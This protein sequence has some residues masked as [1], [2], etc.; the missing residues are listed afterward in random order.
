MRKWQKQGFL[1]EKRLIIWYYSRNL[2]QQMP[3]IHELLSEA[4]TQKLTLIQG[5]LLEFAEFLDK[6]KGTSTLAQG[7][8]EGRNVKV[9]KYPTGYI[10]EI[11]G[12]QG[13]KMSFAFSKNDF[14]VYS[15]LNGN[16]QLIAA[17]PDNNN[18]KGLSPHPAVL[19]K[20]E[21]LTNMLDRRLQSLRQ[22]VPVMSN[23]AHQSAE[24]LLG[25]VLSLESSELSAEWK[26]NSVDDLE[27]RYF[28]PQSRGLPANLH[29]DSDDYPFLG[30]AKQEKTEQ[31]YFYKS[32]ISYGKYDFSNKDVGWKFHL[33]VLPEHAP[34]VSK[35]LKE[36]NFYHKYLFGGEPN[37][38]KIFTLYIGSKKLADQLA[39]ELNRDIGQYLAYPK[40][41]EEIEFSRGVVGRFCAIREKNYGKGYDKYVQYGTCGTSCLRTN[42]LR[43]NE[44]IC[45][46][47]PAL[48]KQGL[49][50]EEVKSKTLQEAISM[51]A[52]ATQHL[53]A[54]FGE[55]FSG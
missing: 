54:D 52:A 13:N 10:I 28:Y 11:T 25:S 5:R 44:L 14:R 17:L 16:T 1:L 9:S 31:E 18:K 46:T 45:K 22:I 38:G 49:S 39:Q 42:L 41:L 48:E 35:Y 55:Y 34:L 6:G 26:I 53:I 23:T 43:Y 30:E 7:V 8:I 2:F 29:S 51:A 20:M 33:N 40:S 15:I 4:E 3:E 24:Q 32:D 27:R 12:E 21:E 19:Q 36:S 50:K 37:D 47:R